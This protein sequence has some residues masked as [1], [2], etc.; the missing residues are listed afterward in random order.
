[1]LFSPTTNTLTTASMKPY[2]EKKTGTHI[3]VY[4]MFAARIFGYPTL[5]RTIY[6]CCPRRSRWRAWMV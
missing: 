2:L 3:N 4:H 5:S 6:Q 1:M